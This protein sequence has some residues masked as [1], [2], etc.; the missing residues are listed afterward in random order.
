MGWWKIDPNT[1]GPAE[2]GQSKLSQPPDF[3]LLNAVPGV[4]DEEN[5]TYL[6]DGPLDMA[7]TLLDELDSVLGGRFQMSGDEFRALFSSALC[8]SA[9]VVLAAR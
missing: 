6:G 2:D 5:A 3:T 8:P 4:D 7:S 9:P 1:G